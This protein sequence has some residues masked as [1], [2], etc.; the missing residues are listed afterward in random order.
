VV[1]D[2]SELAARD[3]L[4]DCRD[5]RIRVIRR[6]HAGILYLADTYNVALQSARG[7]IVAIL[8]DDDLWPPHKLERQLPYFTNPDV[9]L[10]WGI[11]QVIDSE[12]RV[13]GKLPNDPAAL[14]TTIRDNAPP[15]RILREL[16]VRNIIPACTVM[17]RKQALLDIGGFQGLG[18]V[19]VDYPTWL[20]LSLKTRFAFCSETCGFWRMHTNQ[21]S[22][23][24]AIEQTE[25][26][27]R[28]AL[29]FFDQLPA[30]V[31]LL[32][33]F[34]RATL[35]T[36]NRDRLAQSHL[37]RGRFRALE[38]KW[39]E[40]RADFWQ[41]LQ[42]GCTRTRAKAAAAMVL[43]ALGVDVERCVNFVG[44]LPF[45]GEVH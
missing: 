38:H 13:L 22:H 20:A 25:T 19:Y 4:A 6:D 42:K 43:T 17:I 31:Q 24:R 14:A 18:L 5:P 1:D 29:E 28:L 9:A 35:V 23:A 10:S 32:I 7:S 8:E 34:R 44:G 36:R 41:A 33:G 2:G 45:R 37:R 15:G 11:A 12:G 27:V 26:G 40:A 16:L 21:T 30:E 3:V 39:S